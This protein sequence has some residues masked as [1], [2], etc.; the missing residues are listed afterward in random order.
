MN[1][2]TLLTWFLPLLKKREGESKDLRHIH[3]VVYIVLLCGL[4]WQY[5][6]ASR[7][8]VE[9]DSIRWQQAALQAE[10]EAATG[11]AQQATASLA[12]AIKANKALKAAEMAARASLTRRQASDLKRTHS[13]AV[14]ACRNAQKAIYESI[15][16]TDD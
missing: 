3:L 8:K 5:W 13:D 12:D 10:A 9:M 7:L 14:D 6:S 4:V 1:P 15:F 16:S 11:R 2:L